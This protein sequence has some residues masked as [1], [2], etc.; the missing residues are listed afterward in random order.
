MRFLAVSL[1]NAFYDLFRGS[2]ATIRDNNSSITWDLLVS[3]TPVG[4]HRS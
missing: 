3:E 2:E 1:W 4:N